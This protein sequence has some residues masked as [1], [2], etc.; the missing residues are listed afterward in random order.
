MQN[1]TD[2]RPTEL[3]GYFNDILAIPRVSKKEERIISYLQ[4]FAEARGLEHKQDRVGNLLI[5]KKASPGYED[6]KTIILQSHVDMVGEK[7]AE[8]EHDFERDPI[9]ARIVEGWV[10]A[11]GTTLGADDGIGVAAA[12]AI[13]ADKGLEHGPLEC[14]FTIDEESGMTGALGLE[15]GFL[16]GS[17]LLNLDSEDEGEI[18]IGCAGGMDTV[19]SFPYRLV[20]AKKD[21]LSYRIHV[22]GLLGGHSGDEIHKGLG[23]SI[24]LLNRFLWRLDRDLRIRMVSIAGGKARNAIPREAEALVSIHPKDIGSFRTLVEQYQHILSAEFRKVDPGAS[25]RITEAEAAKKV[26][27]KKDQRALLDGLYTMP[28]GMIAMSQ[29]IEGLVETSTNL[30]AITEKEAGVLEVIT[31]QRSSSESA[32]LAIAERLEAQFRQMGAMF[33]HSG[34]YPGWQPDP[35]S[36][37]LKLSEEVYRDLFK[38]DAEVKAIHAGLECGLFLTKYPDLDMIS[39]GPT[40]R[41]AHSPDERIEIDTVLKFWDFLVELLKRAPQV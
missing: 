37:V 8:V 18:F 38:N 2:L 39:I 36:E 34:G 22:N 12:M 28:H 33:R 25:I 7:H 27:K 10:R 21:W 9:K 17:I 40:I 26:F 14:F 31:S 4:D 13:L 41:G 30:A 19:G 29:D 23:N 24:K 20:P 3:W 6:R 5:S 11:E 35:S 1:I 15:P 16:S 32:K